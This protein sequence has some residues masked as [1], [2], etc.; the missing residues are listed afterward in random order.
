MRA[1]IKFIK[2]FIYIIIHPYATFL[3]S[4]KV[5]ELNPSIFKNKKVA[6][7]GPAE[8]AVK[9]NQGDN[10]DRY[11]LIIRMNKSLE[12]TRDHS[13]SQFIGKRT[14]I[15]FR[16][17]NKETSGEWGSDLHQPNEKEIIINNSKYQVFQKILRIYA[18]TSYRGKLY[19]IPKSV[20]ES[21]KKQLDGYHPTTGIIAFYLLMN[22]KFDEVYISGF[23]FFNTGY[24]DGYR[25]G[26]KNQKKRI[27]KIG[28]HSPAKEEVFFRKKIKSSSKNIILD[29]YLS[30]LVENE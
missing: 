19:T 2:T 12:L 18:R 24:M 11:D 28:K 21:L 8:T 20:I 22:S 4:T 6:I 5:E 27:N 15:L 23:T 14:D 26:I 16:S 3:T 7:I 17:L 25:D 29:E 10:I 9:F 1:L 30:K 13:H